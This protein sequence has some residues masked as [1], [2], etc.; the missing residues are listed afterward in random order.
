MC[1]T[2]MPCDEPACYN[3]LDHFPIRQILATDMPPVTFDDP[4]DE[5]DDDDYDD[6]NCDNCEDYD[7]DDDDTDTRPSDDKRDEPPTYPTPLQCFGGP[8]IFNIPQCEK[9]GQYKQASGYVSGVAITFF[10]TR[11]PPDGKVKCPATHKGPCVLCKNT[12]FV[13]ELS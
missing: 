8:G 2:K 12:G 6:G 5:Y 13:E 7:D 1:T 9:C 4:D 10:C 11:C 3:R